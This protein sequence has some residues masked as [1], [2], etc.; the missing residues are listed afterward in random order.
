MGWKDFFK[1]K[2]ESLDPLKD[3]T[4]ANLKVGYFV[5][6]DL[7]SWQVTAS[8]YYDWGSGDL[9]YEWQLKSADETIYL[10]REPDDEDYWSISQK[11]SID[12]LGAHLKTY[13]TEHGDP[14][15]QIEYAGKTYYLEET[16]GGYFYA[17]DSQDRYQNGKE[18]L[19]WDF[20]D[21]SG[22][23]FVSIEQWGETEFEASTGKSV[24]EYQF[25]DILPTDSADD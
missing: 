1:R 10:E 7:K 24:E 18:L 11:I 6:Y 16:G 12:Q 21:D 25:T 4:L 20:T 19:K 22:E 2:K 14:P 13:I 8:N 23:L 9:T 15:E 3:L 17:G 5:D